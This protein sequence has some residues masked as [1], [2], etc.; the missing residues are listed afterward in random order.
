LL[1]WLWVAPSGGG[2]ERDWTFPHQLLTVWHHR[3]TSRA[4]YSRPG[5]LHDAATEWCGTD[6]NYSCRKS[7]QSEWR[8]NYCILSRATV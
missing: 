2:S 7:R 5:A 1:P 8:N 6:R 4:G 3:R